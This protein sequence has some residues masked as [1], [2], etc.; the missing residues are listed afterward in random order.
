MIF[1]HASNALVEEFTLENLKDQNGGL[2]IN[3]GLYLHQDALL[4]SR[5]GRYVYKVEVPDTEQHVVNVPLGQH[6]R[7]CSEAAHGVFDFAQFRYE[8]RARGINM[9]RLTQTPGL[10]RAFYLDPPSLKIID[11]VDRQASPDWGAFGGEVPAQMDFD[12]VESSDE[13]ALQQLVMAVRPDGTL[14]EA[15]ILGYQRRLV[16]QAI[17]QVLERPIIPLLASDEVTVEQIKAARALL[18]W[19]QAALAENAGIAVSTVA[20]YERGARQPMPQNLHAMRLAL[21]VHGVIFTAG[22]VRGTATSGAWA[23]PKEPVPAKLAEAETIVPWKW[24]DELEAEANALLD[25]GELIETA[26]A[27]VTGGGPGS[28]GQPP[29]GGIEGREAHREIHVVRGCDAR[30]AWDEDGNEWSVIG[31][32]D[33]SRA[34]AHARALN[35]AVKLVYP[36][37]GRTQAADQGDTAWLTKILRAY[38]PIYAACANWAYLSYH[39]ESVK[40]GG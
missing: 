2:D 23:T 33:K 32:L 6:N 14:E 5:N 8:M 1:F 27:V 17:H 35:M 3:L 37:G 26:L 4:A 40:F 36:E 39:V 9:L 10:T 16:V 34:E 11:R 12:W 28:E 18:N 21:E 13:A 7:R 22:G 20:D 29:A 24:G 19:T 31:Y 15:A 30:G 25:T 38:D